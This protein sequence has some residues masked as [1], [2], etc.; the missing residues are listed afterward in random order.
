VFGE[1]AVGDLRGLLRDLSARLWSNADA[2][3]IVAGQ[4]RGFR[5]LYVKGSIAVHRNS[6][7]WKF[8]G[9]LN[10]GTVRE[11]F[12][13]RLTDPD[14]FDRETP[15]TFEF[16]DRRPDREYAGFVQDQMR[17]GDWT[18][19]AGLRWDRYRLVVSEGAFSPRVG[20]AWSWPEKDLVLRASYDRAFQTPAIENL[21]LASSPT[22][23]QLN[24]SVLR[25]PVRP[26]RG[27]FYEAG[28]SKR[29]FRSVRLDVTRFSRAMADFADDDLLLNTGVSF[30]VAFRRAEIHGAELKL[31]V[32]AWRALSGFVSYAYLRGVGELPITGGL[33]LGNEGTRLLTARERFPVSQDQRNTVR[34][35]VSY[36]LGKPVW[37][38]LA[39]SYGS[40]LP[41]E[42]EGDRD[43]ALEQYGPRI[44]DRVD[45]E[46]GRVRP[47][48]SLDAAVGLAIVSRGTRELRLHADVRNLTNRLNVINFSG[49]FSGTALA[50]PRSVG[51]RLQA[52]F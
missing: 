17:L 32:P 1:N 27:N 10:V 21:L 19:N 43:L 29:L 24:D 5:E 36:Q 20:V 30:P 31:D 49:L 18:V 50:P 4:D 8:G 16:D 51:V 13:F 47:A 38:A 28:L 41:V 7:E 25:L 15:A 48:F 34:G 40:G 26:S 46:A 33:W 22:T 44:V 35:R 14:R 45:L 37:I 3:P 12:G 9:D 23:D 11:Q 2:I 39:A 6:H 42:F 52:T